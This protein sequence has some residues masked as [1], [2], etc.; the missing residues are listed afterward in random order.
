M[1]GMVSP[2]YLDRLVLKFAHAVIAQHDL[3]KQPVL[4]FRI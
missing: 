1:S 4:L 2:A 3:L